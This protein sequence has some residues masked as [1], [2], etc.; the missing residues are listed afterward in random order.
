MQCHLFFVTPNMEISA[1][2][3]STSNLGKHA[4][5]SFGCVLIEFTDVGLITIS[6]SSCNCVLYGW[7]HRHPHKHTSTQILLTNVHG[8]TRTNVDIDTKHLHVCTHVHIHS[9]TSL[10]GF[11]RFWVYV[12]IELLKQPPAHRHT[13]LY[14]FFFNHKMGYTGHQPIMHFINMIID[15]C[16]NRLSWGNG[17]KSCFISGD[18]WVYLF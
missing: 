18:Q 9:C 15:N 2:K 5:V 11:V 8:V 4:A 7:A 16:R 17:L 12:R 1:Y 3:N 13:H 14:S 6:Y 10:T